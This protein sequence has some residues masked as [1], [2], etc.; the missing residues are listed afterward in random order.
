MTVIMLAAGFYMAH[1]RCVRLVPYVI[2]MSVAL[3]IAFPGA[4][5]RGLDQ[6]RPPVRSCRIR[7]A[8]H[9]ST[10]LSGRSDSGGA[11]LGA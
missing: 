5:Q 10:D 8:E 6:P 11:A 1:A 9:R 4:L 3:V 2:G 7:W